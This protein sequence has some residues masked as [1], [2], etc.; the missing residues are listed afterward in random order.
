MV[1]VVCLKWGQPYGPDYVNKLY[2]GVTRNL[3]LPLRFVCFTDNPTGI[4]PAVEC[5]PLPP[6]T[7]PPGYK[8]SA[9]RK[10]ALFAAELSDLKGPTLFLDLDVVIVNNIDSFFEFEAP[11]CIIH[12]WIERR[13]TIFR[14]RPPI[15]NS[16]VFRFVIGEQA[17]VLDDFHADPQRAINGF[18]TEQAYMSDTVTGLNFWPERWCRSFKRHCVL[19]PPLNLVAAPHIPG[20][21]KIIAFHGRPNPDE[22]AE[23]VSANWRRRSLPAKWI[24]RHWA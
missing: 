7:L 17:H 16:S 24:D 2:R 1:N 5:G 13:K 23:G 21:A 20:G 3:T 11:F 6:I 10:I 9:F 12:N 8:N 4:D 18:P 14:K 22:A 15:G 19:P